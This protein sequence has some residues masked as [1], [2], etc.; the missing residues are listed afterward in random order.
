MPEYLQPLWNQILGWTESYGY[1]AVIPTLVLDPAGV[2][3]AWIFLLMI[4]QEARLNVPVMLLYGFGVLTAMDHAFYA[5]GFFGGRPLLEKLARRWPKLAHSMQASEAAMRGKGIWMVTVGRY[6]PIVGRW[7]GVGA[8]LA[9]VPYARFALF[10]AIGVGLTTL[11]FGLVA[12]FIGR[13]ISAEPWF[14][15]AVLGAYIFS[16][17]ATA[18][19]TFYGVWRTRRKLANDT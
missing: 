15:Q 18:V 2:P 4:A 1:H 7:V 6:V 8:G 5:L 13:E 16:T 10:D 17:V 12:H 9:N 19:L 11:G 3:W 14:P